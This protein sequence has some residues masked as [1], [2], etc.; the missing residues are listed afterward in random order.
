[1]HACNWLAH[2]CA[3]TQRQM[4]AHHGMRDR[5]ASIMHS[6]VSVPLTSRVLHQFQEVNGAQILKWNS[7]FH[8]LRELVTLFWGES[9]T[10]LHW[11]CSAYVVEWSHLSCCRN[12]WIW[13]MK[14]ATVM[15]QDVMTQEEQ[16]SNYQRKVV[17]NT[18][19]PLLC[20]LA[21]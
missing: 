16:Q 4:T 5:K 6:H 11:R 12:G 14:P 3:Q 7:F 21:I 20:I 1:M 13:L 15:T 17:K 10:V 18:W 9:I 19:I 8:C 2:T